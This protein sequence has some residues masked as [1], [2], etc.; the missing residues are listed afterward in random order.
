VTLALELSGVCFERNRREILS[1][2]SLSVMPG[3][4]V[5]LIGNNGAGKSTLLRVAAGV[6]RP[7]SGGVRVCGEPI[8]EMTPAKRSRLLTWCA[9]LHASVSGISV[10]QFVGMSQD[11]NRFV[12][13]RFSPNAQEQRA[14]REALGAFDATHLAHQN[15]DCL[16]SGEWQRVQLA[17]AWV[18]P[19]KLLLLDEPSTALDLRHVSGLIHSAKKFAAAHSAAVVFSSHDFAFVQALADRVVVLNNGGVAF[20]GAARDID[21]KKMGEVFGVPFVTALSPCFV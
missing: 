5:A 15:V 17:R 13:G 19:A 2:V 1:E 8:E 6:W 16:S 11:R 10:Q 14:I 7:S 3:E 4:I 21:A 9:G 20:C 12:E 18:N